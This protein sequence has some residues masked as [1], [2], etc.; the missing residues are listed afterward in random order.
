MEIYDKNKLYTFIPTNFS[1][2]DI[3]KMSLIQSNDIYEKHN[4][5]AKISGELIC[6]NNYDNIIKE[7]YTNYEETYTN[8]EETLKLRDLSKDKW[9][10]NIIDGY[11]EQDKIIF[12]DELFILIPT[13]TWNLIDL[14]KFHLLAIIKDKNLRSI[15]DLRNEHIDLLNHIKKISLPIIET[16]YNINSNKIKM[17]FHYLP[18]TYQL[19]I[20]FADI[21]NKNVNSSVEYSHELNIVIYNLSLYSEYYKKINLL[22][23]KTH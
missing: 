14:K 13:Y 19:H 6:C 4:A 20:H 21:N 22:I 11:D 10:Y 2:N 3:K 9:I 18:S 23:Y 17:Y 12:Q 8:Y 16:K 5:T 7:T 15:R 1:I